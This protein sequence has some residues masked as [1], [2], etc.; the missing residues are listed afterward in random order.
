[1]TPR[2]LL[3]L[4]MVGAAL[5]VPRSV[6][7]CSRVLA[8]EAPVR[9]FPEGGPVPGNLIYFKLKVAEP[10][11]LTLRSSDGRVVPA[12]IR[13][14]GMDRVFAPD[15]DVPSDLQLELEYTSVCPLGLQPTQTTFAFSTAPAQPL[16]IPTPTLSVEERGESRDHGAAYG[17]LAASVS[18]QYKAVCKT[19]SAAHLTDTHFDGDEGWGQIT[20]DSIEL[21]TSCEGLQ[22][23][24]SCTGYV[25]APPG[26][27]LVKAWSTVVGESEPPTRTVREVE[28]RCG[29]DGCAVGGARQAAH[30]GGAA[31][32]WVALALLSCRRRAPAR[33]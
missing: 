23:D 19:C 18:L 33:A 3:T 29:L 6:L 8:C 22:I 26:N 32:A 4:C 15:A 14:I 13:T 11:A 25:L 2:L 16:E 1:M 27:Y 9:L 24:N 7:A 21:L 10:G 30:D 12:S 5:L 31:F 28:L 17:V 20:G